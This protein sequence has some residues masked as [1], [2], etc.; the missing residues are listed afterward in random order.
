MP[1]IFGV[2]CKMLS[3]TLGNKEKQIL[4]VNETD[5]LNEIGKIIVRRRKELHI[6]QEELA[7]SANVDRTYIGYIENGKQNISIS[8][9]CKI[10]NVLDLDMKDFFKP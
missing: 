6:T 4:M 2:K 1:N 7:Y 3:R 10:A 9:L 8:I 5:V